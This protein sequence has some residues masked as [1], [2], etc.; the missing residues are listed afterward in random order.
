MLLN[1]LESNTLYLICYHKYEKE[2]FIQLNTIT[3]LTL[4]LASA[5]IPAYSRHF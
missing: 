4:I 5:Y 3:V 2:Q 1:S